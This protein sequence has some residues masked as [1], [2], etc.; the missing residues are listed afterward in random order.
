MSPT[1]RIGHLWLVLGA[2]TV[3][4]SC[5]TD[6]KEE[7][8]TGRGALIQRHSLGTIGSQTVAALVGA[9]DAS[10]VDSF[11]FDHDIDLYK[12][13]YE[14]IDHA[15][16]PTTASGLLVVP[17]NLTSPAPIVSFQH[18][19]ILKKNDV[20]SALG[21]GKELG[22]IYAAAGFVFA[23]PDYLGLGEGPGLHPYVHAA[24]EASAVIDMLRATR[25]ACSKLATDLNGQVFLMGYSQGGH[26]TAAA[27]R[28]I[29][30][31]HS[32][33]FDLTASAPMAT[34]FDISGIMADYTMADSAYSS[35]GYIPYILYAFNQI[36][37]I[38]DPLESIFVEPY[39]SLLPLYINANAPFSLEQLESVL[40]ASKI[41]IDIIKFDILQQILTNQSHP[42]WTA[43]QD[44]DVYDWMP[45]T[46][47]LLCHCDQ[48]V[49]VPFE[50]STKAMARFN[51]LGFSDVDLVNPFSGGDHGTCL[52][53]SI[54]RSY[55]WLNTFRE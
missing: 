51:Q 38:F 28:E 18:G 42:F 40:P 29:E 46:P 4:F 24:S 5:S 17:K 31:N 47:M 8:P 6:E 48:D 20:P 44:N 34:P 37:D 3:L 30:A 23:A 39:D 15:G 10:L 16:Q 1:W 55:G 19:T 2:L 9:F 13:I 26:A 35:P 22:W 50:N 12:L 14:T 49:D 7:A 54:V 41:P 53:P 21:T 32:I 45:V 36:Y 33:E 43:L 27:Q 11:V 52:I 25:S